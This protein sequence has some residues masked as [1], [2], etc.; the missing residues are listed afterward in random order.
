[1]WN[2][3]FSLW[4]GARLKNKSEAAF[5]T[6]LSVGYSNYRSRRN[7]TD[8]EKSMSYHSRT[9]SKKAFLL[10]VLLLVC[11]NTFE[12][13]PFHFIFFFK[14]FLF[15]IYFPSLH[16]LSSS[17]FSSSRHV[18]ASFSFPAVLPTIIYAFLSIC[19][20]VLSQRNRIKSAWQLPGFCERV[21]VP[22]LNHCPRGYM[23]LTTSS[24]YHTHLHIEQGQACS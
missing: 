4:S 5:K 7:I 13:L 22:T 6:C 12:S 11:K 17:V 20:T 3:I 1:M 10:L 24:S 19:S 2:I 9:K 15:S 18:C 23:N 21:C 14:N 8:E 16:F